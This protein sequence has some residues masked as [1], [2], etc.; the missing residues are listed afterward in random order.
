MFLL[1]L[2]NL[3]QNE[4]YDYLL[5]IL[6]MLYLFF[7]TFTRRNEVSWVGHQ[8]SNASQMQAPPK[9]NVHSL[10]LRNDNLFSS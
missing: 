2:Q 8:N 9:L 1:G 5:Q 6:V 10:Q 3:A 4:H 7:R